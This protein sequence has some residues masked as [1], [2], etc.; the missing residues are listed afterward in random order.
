[1]IYLSIVNSFPHPAPLADF[2]WQSL[3]N[4]APQYGFLGGIVG[5]FGLIMGATIAI[6]YGFTRTFNAWKPPRNSALAGLDMM[7]TGL[8]AVALVALWLFATPDNIVAYVRRAFWLVGIG[9][10]AFIIYVGLRAGPGRFRK[11][12]VVDNKP[13]D[14]E[15]IWGGFWLTPAARADYRSGKS[16]Q[17]ILAGNGYNVDRVWPGTSLAAAAMVT[18]IVLLAIVAGGTTGLSSVATTA[19]VAL[20]KKPAREALTS[21][22]VPGLP[23]P[24]PS[25]TPSLS[26]TPDQS[27]AKTAE[28]PSNSPH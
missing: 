5:V 21:T 12:R 25:P 9:I 11:P 14:D 7:I 27:Q 19:Q 4:D 28:S 15:V 24:S 13:A 1:M 17:E 8:C 6:L 18:A 2:N 16:I 22:Q 10:V 20:T 3:V 23:T 26:N